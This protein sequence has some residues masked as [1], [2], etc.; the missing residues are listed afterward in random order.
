VRFV[1]LL[2]HQNEV[3]RVLRHGRVHIG[4][5]TLKGGEVAVMLIQEGALMTNSIIDEPN[6]V[7]E[8]FMS[9][10]GGLLV[11]PSRALNLD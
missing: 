10:L 9:E 8:L 2:N 4:E 6:F 1:V 3:L 11:N 5:L 7:P